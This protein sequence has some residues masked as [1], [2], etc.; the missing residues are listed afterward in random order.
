MPIKSSNVDAWLAPDPSRRA[1]LREILA[2]RERPYYE[3]QLAA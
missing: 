1:Q 3:H 2:D